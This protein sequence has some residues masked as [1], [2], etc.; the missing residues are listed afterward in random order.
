MSTAQRALPLPPLPDEAPVEV[1][2]PRSRRWPTWLAAVALTMVIGGEGALAL[3]HD[4]ARAGFPAET[5]HDGYTDV[6]VMAR[7]MQGWVPAGQPCEAY[8]CEAGFDTPGGPA[9]WSWLT[10]QGAYYDNRNPLYAAPAAAF[11][12]MLPG[13]APAPSLGPRL[14]MALLLAG[15]FELGR[16]ARGAWTGVL[17]ATLAAGTPGVFALG[18]MHQDHVPLAALGTALGIALLRTEGFARLRWS[19]AAAALSVLALRTAEN[20]SGAILV[21]L[22]GL[23]PALIAVWT[24]RDGVRKHPESAWA[25]GT[26][27]ALVAGTA[28]AIAVVEGRHSGPVSPRGY[29]F[30]AVTFEDQIT[31]FEDMAWIPVRKLGYLEEMARNLVRLPMLVPLLLGL[32]NTVRADARHRLAIAGMHLVPLLWLSFTL[33]KGSWYLVPALPAL[34]VAGAVGLASLRRAWLRVALCGLAVLTAVWVRVGAEVEPD[35]LRRA[36]LERSIGTAA[37]GVLAALNPGNIMDGKRLVA[38]E[39]ANP[40][41]GQAAQQVAELADRLATPEYPVTRVLVLSSN[42][43]LARGTCWLVELHTRAATCFTP[44]AFVGTPPDATLDADRYDLVVWSEADGLQPLVLAASE[45]LPPLLEREVGKLY[46]DQQARIRPLLD[47]LHTRA[48]TAETL[49]AGPVLRRA[50]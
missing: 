47:A 16:M 50:R 44:I 11:A 48:W 14:W 45:P 37:E 19:A 2:Q 25:R 1:M 6:G 34:A 27:L 12:S 46:P 26:G 29:L 4:A 39:P 42:P 36:L 17:A 20:A 3:H 24:A 21:G 33:R 7:L 10:G 40:R 22:V 13:W 5:H 15:V 38:T 23:A 9:R 8:N 35:G 41:Q 43:T 49:A 32:L 30:T 18:M 31:W 28:L